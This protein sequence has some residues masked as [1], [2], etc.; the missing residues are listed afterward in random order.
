MRLTN[1]IIY[2]N[3]F[4]NII[5]YFWISPKWIELQKQWAAMERSSNGFVTCRVTIKKKMKKRNTI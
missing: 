1:A 4:L 5:I 3:S 2:G